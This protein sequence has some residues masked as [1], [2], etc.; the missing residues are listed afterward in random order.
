MNQF[1]LAVIDGTKARFLTLEPADLSE[2]KSRPHFIEQKC[3]LNPD[4]E[5]QGQELWA[6]AKTGRN[7]GIAGQAHSYDDGRD[8]HRV[9]FE[10]RFAQMITTQILHLIEAHQAQQLLLIAEPKILGLVRDVLV[11]VLPKKV[12]INELAKSLC[13]LNPHELFE[14]LMSKQLLPA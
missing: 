14:Y 12:T 9:E 3:L 6:S 7:R 2:P 11:P 5:L 13:Q 8:H 4:Q 10:R 1:L